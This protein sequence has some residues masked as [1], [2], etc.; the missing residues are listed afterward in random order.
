[1]SPC[2]IERKSKGEGKMQ[3]RFRE[4]I[5]YT[6]QYAEVEVF[7]VFPKPRS[8]K[9]KFQP[10]SELQELINQNTAE[11]KCMRLIHANFTGDDYCIG[12]DY[13]PLYEPSHIGQVKKDIKNFL[14]RLKRRY[15]KLGVALKYIYSIEQ[16]SRFNIHVIL[17][18][19]MSR[20]EIE[21]CWGMGHANADRLQFSEFGVMDLANYVQKQ[22]LTYRRW[23]SS[24]NLT[25]PVEREHYIS[26]KT[27]KEYAES[28]NVQS[29]IERNFPDYWLVL[30][31]SECILNTT[32]GFDYVRLFLCRKDAQLSFYSTSFAEFD[33]RV[34]RKI[35]SRALK[36][37]PDEI[38]VQNSLFRQ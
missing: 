14:R 4:H 17:N 28:W 2:V 25:Q 35:D 1:M 22:R 3:T 16:A 18:N 32:N 20:D 23:V 11:R 13:S 10:S 34:R 31:D 7:P 24:R 38:W 33:D 30:D 19:G 5:Y 15:D 37:Q 6:G 8:R 36:L 12:F 27:A 26:N 21:K 29:F 9:H